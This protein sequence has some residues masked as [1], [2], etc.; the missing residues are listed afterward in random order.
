M[1]GS[2]A[3]P[4]GRRSDSVL[5]RLYRWFLLD[6]NRVAVAGVGLVGGFLL[7][8]TI[9]YVVDGTFPTPPSHQYGQTTVPLVSALLSG[10]FLL[11]SIVV[12]VNSLFVTQEVSALDR[13]FRRIQSVVEYRRQLENVLD[14]DHVPAEPVQFVRLLSAEILSRAQSIDDDLHTSEVDLRADLDSYLTSLATE[15]GE[16]NRQL[17]AAASNA[18][19][20]IA[21][22]DYNHDR[23]IHDLRRLQSTH[24]DTL[25][26]RTNESIDDLLQLLQYVATGRAYFKSLYIR[27]EFANLSR[28]LVFTS[29]VSVATTASF[30]HFLET[31]PAPDLLVTG[32]EAIALAPFILVG[33]YVLRVSAV[34]RR[35]QAAG[36]FVVSDSVTG[37]VEG[38]APPERSD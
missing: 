2:A 5:G 4:D 1:L 20:V 24:S 7:V 21:M 26:E 8:G 14:V 33:S 25:P 12:S 34:S 37:D 11:F 16:M 27:Q 35:T 36:Q 38:I 22:M 28:N 29:V 6:G 32:V 9:G 13:E 30:L 3:P 31:I 15:T 10:N 23:Q 17:E 19:L 18:D